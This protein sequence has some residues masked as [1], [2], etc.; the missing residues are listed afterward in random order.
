MRAAIVHLERNLRRVN[1]RSP[2]RTIFDGDSTIEQA[3][4]NDRASAV[5]GAQTSKAMPTI[6]ANHRE[7]IGMAEKR[8]GTTCHERCAWQYQHAKLQ[9]TPSVMIAHH[10]SASAKPKRAR[11]DASTRVRGGPVARL[12]SPWR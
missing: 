3:P 4:T 10:L 5:T 6:L 11:P 8:V 2:E 12:L 7:V 1:S 9:S